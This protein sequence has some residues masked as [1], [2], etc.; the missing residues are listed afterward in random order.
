MRPAIRPP[1]KPLE[2][3]PEDAPPPRS[4][5]MNV[6][7]HPG[8]LESQ[9][10]CEGRKTSAVTSESNLHADVHADIKRQ[11]VDEREGED[12][13]QLVPS[14]LDRAARADIFSVMLGVGLFQKH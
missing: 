7:T 9:S 2:M 11:E 12:V 4:S 13:R 8:V 14:L 3:Y 1:K 5:M 6:T 10:R